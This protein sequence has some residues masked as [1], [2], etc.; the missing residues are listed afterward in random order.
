MDQLIDDTVSCNF[1]RYV[2]K[3]VVL[4]DLHH[5]EALPG[6]YC[7]GV[8]LPSEI[9]DPSWDEDLAPPSHVN[10]WWE[11]GIGGMHN[12]SLYN[13]WVCSYNIW[14]CRSGIKNWT[15][16]HSSL[17]RRGS[18]GTRVGTLMFSWW[19]NE[20][21]CQGHKWHWYG[22]RVQWGLDTDPAL[23]FITSEIIR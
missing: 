11:M 15:S 19:S 21:Y 22:H 20:R 12:V 6:G 16:L 13:I 4:Y 17:G 7:P 10:S 18:L 3:E 1:L 8:S 5:Q 14:V 9:L 23:W 2:T